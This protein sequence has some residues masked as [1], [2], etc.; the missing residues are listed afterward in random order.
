V[1]EAEWALRYLDVTD[2]WTVVI[3]EL[4]GNNPADALRLRRECTYS[5]IADAWMNSRRSVE[6]VGYRVETRK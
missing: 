5:D 2:I 6:G 4:A 1:I 3:L